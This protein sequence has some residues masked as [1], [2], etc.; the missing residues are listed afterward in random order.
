ME[1]KHPEYY[2]SK[3]LCLIEDEVA[4][5]KLSTPCD[6]AM[7][8]QSRMSSKN[9]YKKDGM[10]RFK[11]LK[12]LNEL[13]NPIGIDATLKFNNWIYQSANV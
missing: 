12:A 5:K 1:L 9:I 7:F 4:S 13:F 2:M 3:F 6:E 10:V 8:E 11:D